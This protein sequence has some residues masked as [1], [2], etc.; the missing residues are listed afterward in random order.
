MA[1]ALFWI[2]LINATLLILHEMDSAYWHEWEL[3]RLPGG[4]GGFLLLHIPL[5]VPAL[6]GLALVW[7]GAPA[8][9][10]LSLALSL[11][12]MFAFALHMVFIRR[13]REEFKTPVSLGILA[14][15]LLASLVQ[16]A[17]TLAR[18]VM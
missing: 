1:D 15:T 12:G 3:L 4:V 18:L 13:G 16:A 14:A 8:G 9:L 6:Y 5:L 10:A 11:A 2:Y 7:R 17:L